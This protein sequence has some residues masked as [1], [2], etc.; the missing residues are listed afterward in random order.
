MALSPSPSSAAPDPEPAPQK[1]K[2]T[3]SA[4]VREN[5]DPLLPKNKKAHTG[6]ETCTRA[7]QKVSLVRPSTLNTEPVCWQEEVGEVP[8]K[9]GEGATLHPKDPSD[10]LGQA[11][12][13]AISANTDPIDATVISDSG[14]EPEA[15]EESCEA[16]LSKNHIGE[17]FQK[18]LT[19]H[20]LPIQ[21]V[22]ISHL[23]I[24]PHNSY[25]QIYCWVSCSCLPM[26]C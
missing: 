5:T 18:I 6:T 13:I 2:I 24:L 3:A 14:S 19:Y 25:C 10:I 16:E 11:E 15:A 7:K 17:I 1:R 12:V 23:C 8:N 9:N 22:D 20:R 26:P 21:R 4:H